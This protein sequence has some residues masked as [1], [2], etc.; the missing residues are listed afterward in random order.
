M[1]RIALSFRGASVTWIRRFTAQTSAGWPWRTACSPSSI[2]LPGA[3]AL[4]DA[5]AKGF[6]TLYYSADIHA[7][8]RHLP[9]FVA[10]ALGD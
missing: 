5:R 8:A 1:I 2:R 7:G 9:P 6:Q 3:E 4:N 10:A